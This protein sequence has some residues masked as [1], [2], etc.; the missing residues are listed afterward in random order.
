MSLEDLRALEVLL[1]RSIASVHD[2]DAYVESELE[3]QDALAR[4]SGSVI[5]HMLSNSTRPLRRRIMRLL[6]Q[7]GDV[8][9]SLV[10]MKK[11]LRVAAATRPDEGTVR[12]ALLDALRRQ[13]A[14]FRE[15]LLIRS[16]ETVE[17]RVGQPRG[18]KKPRPKRGGR[19]ALA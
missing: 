13:T 11:M 8:A 1:D 16:P 14:A 7:T 18:R 12:I 9:A 4:I 17:A 3:I 10:G 19:R 6:P 15:G 5:F 2:P